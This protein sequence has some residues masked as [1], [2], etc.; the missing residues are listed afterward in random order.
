MMTKERA[1]YILDNKV[2]GGDFRY[3]F[4]RDYELNG[5]IVHDD[6]ITKAEDEYIRELW[7]TRNLAT[8]YGVICYIAE[9][10]T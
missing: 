10:R 9:G 1:R 3:A 4:K 2:I 8:Y 5:G 7:I 6:G